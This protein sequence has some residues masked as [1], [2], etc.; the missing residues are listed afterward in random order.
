MKKRARNGWQLF[1]AQDWLAIL[2]A[3]GL[4]AAGLTFVYSASWRGDDIGIVGAWFIKQIWWVAL[5]AGVATALAFSDYKL[6]LRHAWWIYLAALALLV[7]VLF[8]GKR[9]YGAYRWLVVF[10]VPVQPSEFAKVALVLLLARVLASPAIR[11]RSFWTVL[12]ALFLVG[13]P[14]GLILLEPDFGTAMILAPTVILVLFAAGCALRHLLLLGAVA[15]GGLALLLS[16]LARFVLSDYQQERIATFLDPG[17]DPLGSGWNALQSAIAVGSGG[18][19]GKGLLN[20]TQNVLGFLP[21]TVAPTDFIFP[22]LAE[23]KGFIGASVL[24]LAFACLLTCYLRTAWTA[25]DPA[26]S[27]LATGI[28]ALLF[29]HVFVNIGMT[30]GLLPITGLPLPFV[31][32]GGSFMV[33]TLAGFGLVQSVHVRRKTREV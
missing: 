27:L 6:W 32:S 7:L 25:K 4:L 29:C 14:G 12:L 11:P 30:I 15:G 13:V 22:V 5:G 33:S 31:S 3:A 23:E 17:R 2:L 10:G 9:V 20:G 19:W 21:R 8:F 16:P 1:V 24:L 28:A 26:G 18:V